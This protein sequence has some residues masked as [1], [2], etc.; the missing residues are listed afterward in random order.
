MLPVSKT[1]NQ[2]QGAENWYYALLRTQALELA[3]LSS[4]SYFITEC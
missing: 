2:N 1:Y 3:K 4:N